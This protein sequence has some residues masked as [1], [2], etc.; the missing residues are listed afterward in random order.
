MCSK[1]TSVLRNMQQYSIA[2]CKQL[3]IAVGAQARAQLNGS[4]IACHKSGV[5]DAREKNKPEPRLNA[6]KSAGTGWGGMGVSLAR[7]GA[8]RVTAVHVASLVP[9]I[10]LFRKRDSNVSVRKTYFE[11][12]Y[13]VCWLGAIY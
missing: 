4:I 13:K 9:S 8:S 3:Q 2:K 6:D 12:R 11:V 7:G 10:G 1:S 5:Y